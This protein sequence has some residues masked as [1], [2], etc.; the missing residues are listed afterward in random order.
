METDLTHPPQGSKAQPS[1]REPLKRPNLSLIEGFGGGLGCPGDKQV[2][3]TNSKLPDCPQGRA[4]ASE[5]QGTVTRPE[6]R[7]QI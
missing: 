6:V 5:S 1:H 7:A 2:G 4:S 3:N